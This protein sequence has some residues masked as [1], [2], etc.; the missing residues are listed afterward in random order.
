[1]SIIAL[2]EEIRDV[3]WIFTD[4]QGSSLAGKSAIGQYVAASHL[5]NSSPFIYVVLECEE[6]E[7]VR[8]LTCRGRGGFYNTKIR[9]PRV[10]REIRKTKDIIYEGQDWF[11]RL[12]LD[13][14]SLNAKEAASQ[15]FQHAAKHSKGLECN[16][17]PKVKPKARIRQG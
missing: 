10:L 4:F 6:E 5:R 14:T 17:K 15:I 1:M 7:N 3:T 8:R 2:D 11:I 9:D 12:K 13:V 16:G